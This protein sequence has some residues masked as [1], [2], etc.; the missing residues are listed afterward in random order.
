MHDISTQKTQFIKQ[1][2][3]DYL[4]PDYVRFL[5]TLQNILGFDPLSNHSYPE[6]VW[7][8]ESLQQFV[9]K[10]YVIKSD[11]QS[12]WCRFFFRKFDRRTQ[13][14]CYSVAPERTLTQGFVPTNFQGVKKRFA[15]MINMI[16]QKHSIGMEK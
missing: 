8:T 3:A 15:K 12:F 5:K 2:E 1:I 11:K 7:N 10:N 16:L 13:G 4:V 6:K 9:N 14:V